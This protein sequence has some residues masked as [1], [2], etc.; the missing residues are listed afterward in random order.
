MRKI[1]LASAVA[2]LGAG[3][4]MAAGSNQ[5]TISVTVLQNCS[6]TDPAD[7]TLSGPAI[8]NGGSSGFDFS[9][10][11][12]GSGTPLPLKIGFQSQN[13]GVNNPS[14]ATRTYDSTYNATVIP[15]ASAVGSPVLV[16]DTSSGPAAV[17]S[18]TF[19]VALT[20][21]LLIAGTYS[22]VLTVSVAP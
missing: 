1:L 18:R 20:E 3:S 5:T 2:V 16:A 10:N 12:G 19:S 17:N 22:D 4:A 7:I 8:G 15:A 9:C 13:G 21:N 14:D 11:F 6:I